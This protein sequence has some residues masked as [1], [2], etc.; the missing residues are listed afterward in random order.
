[1]SAPKRNAPKPGRLPSHDPG[2]LAQSSGSLRAGR[3]GRQAG[4]GARPPAESSKRLLAKVREWAKAQPQSDKSKWAFYDALRKTKRGRGGRPKV[5]EQSPFA[6]ARAVHEQLPRFQ[7]G[8]TRLR[9]LKQERPRQPHW[10]KYQLRKAGFE[11][12]ETDALVRSRTPRAAAQRHVADLAECDLHTV[13]NAC[14]RFKR[15]AKLEIQS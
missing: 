12:R 11:E 9:K 5:G 2:V 4:A 10:W 6:L 8:F 1:M 13:Q 7:Q 14:S 15:P 3:C